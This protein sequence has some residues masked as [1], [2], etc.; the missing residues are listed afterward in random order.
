MTITP[1]QRQAIG[2]E[3]SSWL[4][5]MSEEPKD[6]ELHEQFEAW[7]A[8]SPDH[9]AIWED[10]VRTYSLFGEVEPSHR[11]EWDEFAT[12]R[13]HDRL[14]L[15]FPPLRAQPRRSR[16]AATVSST[17]RRL[18]AA[19]VAAALAILVAPSA[20]LHLRADDITT[21]AEIRAVALADGSRVHL[22]PKSAIAM[23]LTDER[24]EVRLLRGE[25]FFE[26][27]RDPRRPFVVTANGV[28]TTVLGT[29]FDVRLL[30]DGAAVAV[31]H[32]H[33]RVETAKGS[34]PIS[35]HLLA[36]DWLT[37]SASDPI[38][39]GKM[40]LD[41]VAATSRGEIVADK[42]TVRDVV[43]ALRPWYGGAILVVGDELANRTVTGIF[44]ARNPGRV[45]AA[46]AQAHGG[47]VRRV[48][49]WLL[50]LSQS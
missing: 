16:W 10:T 5:L 8:T 14:L 42:R 30:D 35:A 2:D 37:V 6:A 50:I 34:P 3:A 18:A 33:V 17:R 24:R 32:G 49:P 44:D 27:R 4:I 19:A 43:E 38:R 29:A 47:T 36:G 1:A 39:S 21:T 28:R 41:D 48:T 9:A 23:S 45:L 13:G 20:L 46:I 31:E 26:V 25:A 7:R 15:A 40:Q 22:A 12:E 11:A